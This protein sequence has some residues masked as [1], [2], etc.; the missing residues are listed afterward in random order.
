MR[1]GIKW[2][3]GWLGLASV[4]ALAT[5][6]VGC[7]SDE[8]P[9]QPAA[10]LPAAAAAPAPG[11]APA[12]QQQPALPAPALPA[13][14][15]EAVAVPEAVGAGLAGRELRLFPTPIPVTENPVYGGRIIHAPENQ[16]P[17]DVYHASPGAD[18]LPMF[19]NLNAYLLR[20]NPEDR[21]TIEAD[22][23]ESWSLSDDGLSWTFNIRPGLKSHKGLEFDA[24][25]VVYNMTR[26]ME[27][28]NSLRVRRQRCF[29]QLVDNVQ[30]LDELTVKVNL[31]A[32]RAVFASCL[33][34]GWMQ[35]QPMAAIKAKDEETKLRDLRPEEVDGMGPFMFS[36]DKFSRDSKISLDRNPDWHLGDNGVKPYLDGID[37]VYISNYSTFV[38]AAATKRLSFFDVFSG[39]TKPDADALEAQHGSDIT[40]FR[41]IPLGW[42]GHILNV[43][44]PPLDNRDIRYAMQLAIDRQE[45][46]QLATDGIGTFSG[47][48]FGLWDW[49]YSFDDYAKFPGVRQPKDDDIAEARRL[50]EAEGYGPDNRLKLTDIAPTSGFNL[51]QAEV[52]AEHYK[53]IYI[54]V[55]V[56]RLDGATLDERRDRQDADIFTVTFGAEFEDPDAFNGSMCKP[57]GSRNY[58]GWTD[59]K[60]IE[61]DLQQR[62]LEDQGARGP[63]L[64]QMA[65]IEHEAAACIPFIRPADIQGNWANLINYFPP[66][67]HHSAYIFGNVWCKDSQCIP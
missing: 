36:L 8:G 67:L 65:D 49:I 41:I 7:S 5:V 48:Y 3:V 42:T 20:L 9:Q 18:D 37:T 26:I 11:Q 23:A 24:D 39:F 35:F 51:R 32:P 4:V 34:G 33:T 12:A 47:Y 29:S 13:P 15:A 27:R 1:H 6:L 38:A 45:M 40:L 60:W 54:D 55:E 22:L 64:R 58:G 17:L 61:L 2:P 63:I 66:R 31:V 14:E 44:R 62:V 46:N 56:Q 16:P 52:A 53:R 25:D 10:P 28:P 19:T 30:K 59:A 43:T 21:V 50:M 57:G